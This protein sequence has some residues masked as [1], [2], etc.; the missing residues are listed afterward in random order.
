MMDC[1]RALAE[2][3]GDMEQ[4][5]D[6]LRKRGQA[7][8]DKKSSRRASEG[9]IFSH[10]TPDGKVGVLLELN[11]ETD[12]VARNAAFV[13]LGESLLRHIAEGGSGTRNGNLEEL[14]AS[15]GAQTGSV[16]VAELLRN[17]VATLGENIGVGQF[18][19]FEAGSESRLDSYVHHNAKLG[20]Q[21]EVQAAK[22]ETRELADFKTLCRDLAM[23]V[24]S[25]APR[26]LDR[27]AVPPD[28]IEREK[29]IY[30]EQARNEGKA[31]NLLD[32]IALGKVSK[33]YQQ[34]CLTE[35]EFVKNPDETIKQLVERTGKT[36]GDSIKVVRFE[37]IKV[38]G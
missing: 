11:C 13:K 12:F 6:W 28:A 26:W 24:A 18:V 15:S 2:C 3:N 10:L 20:V 17:Q 32:K 9:L 31:E 1:K 14:L 21:V 35:Q 23:H 33:F 34:F 8:A 30:R 7:I 25:A 4:A 29:E 19:R 22:P 5:K 27:S 16:V 37:R 36:L 38:G